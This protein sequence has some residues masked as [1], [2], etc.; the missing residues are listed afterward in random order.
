MSLKLH[1]VNDTMVKHSLPRPLAETP[2]AWRPLSDVNPLRFN[3]EFSF[4]WSPW[5]CERRAPCVAVPFGCHLACF[6][7]SGVLGRRRFLALA[8]SVLLVSRPGPPG[9][10]IGPSARRIGLAR[11][12]PG[13]PATIPHASLRGTA[14]SIVKPNWLRL[15]A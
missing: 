9:L 5:R 14:N 8:I 15:R 10:A 3:S 4:F 7:M 12:C 1:I 6:R 11:R 2:S 13:D